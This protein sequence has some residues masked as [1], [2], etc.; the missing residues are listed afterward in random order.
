MG[1]R[2]LEQLHSYTTR[3]TG[4]SATA[5]QFCFQGLSFEMA[6]KFA[7]YVRN[8]HPIVHNGEAL[9]LFVLDSEH[10]CPDKENFIDEAAAVSRRNDA[11]HHFILLQPYG[12]SCSLSVETTVGVI[13]I[14]N[15]AYDD[16][17]ELCD[18]ELY[19]E[20]VSASVH[21][22]GDASQ[23]ASSLIHA[24]VGELLSSDDDSVNEIWGFLGG[25]LDI[26]ADGMSLPH[27][28][29]YCGYPSSQGLSTAEA[30]RL[31]KTFHKDLQETITDT[32]VMGEM[33][34]SLFSEAERDDTV[35]NES[36][37]T[38]FKE[39]IEAEIPNLDASPRLTFAASYRQD[40]RFLPWWNTIVLKDIT[41]AIRGTEDRTALDISAVDALAGECGSKKQPIVFA[42][43]VKFKVKSN[44]AS[45]DEFQ[46]RKGRSANVPIAEEQ[47][48]AGGSIKYTYAL[49]EEE[50][51]RSRKDAGK[52][53]L[54]LGSKHTK[55]TYPCDIQVLSCLKSGMYLTLKDAE[56]IHKIKPFSVKNRRASKTYRTELTV[57]AAGDITCHL[58]VAD[59]ARLIVAPV[60][61]DDQNSERQYFNFRSENSSVGEL[62]S[63]RI[64]AY[65]ELSFQF[66]GVSNGEEY[67]YEVAFFVK[68]TNS[69]TD[70]SPTWYDEHLRRNLL[71]VTRPLSQSDFQEVELASG[72]DIYQLEQ[73]FLLV[74][75]S[76]LGGYPVI[77]GDDYRAIQRQGDRPDFSMPVS[78]T[79][80]PFATNM[81]TRPDFPAWKASLDSFGSGY[82][83]AR[84]DLF[85]R[86]AVEYPEKRIEE[87]DL[88]SLP[89]EYEAL[90][91]RY[92]KAYGEWLAAD[93]A[94]ASIADQIW[95]YPTRD[96]NTL[97][98]L[99][100]EVIYP[101]YHPLR[102]AWL[103][104]A[105]KMMAASESVQPDPAALIFDSNTIPDM[106]HLPIADI[107][108]RTGSIRTIPF[109]SV[110]SSSY[111]WGVLRD[112]SG[113]GSS[114]RAY[115]H[116]WNEM[117]GLSFEKSAQTITKEQVESALNDAR[118]M[119]L[120][121]PSLSVSFSGTS[122]DSICRDGI[123]SWNRQFI[124]EANND[125]QRLGPRRLKIYDVG[126][127]HMP[128][129]EAIAAIGDQSNGMIQWFAPEGSAGAVDLSIATLAAR[130]RS[131]RESTLG[132][133]VTVAGG[134]GCYRTRQ[135]RAG[136][137]LIE[138]RKTRSVVGWRDGADALSVAISSILQ[139]IVT[140]AGLQIPEEK[141]HIGFP[142]DVRSLLSNEKS[143]Y[144]AVSSADV[145]H[146]CFV[147]ESGS[148]DA[149]LWDY[150]LP[151]N[152]IGSRNADGFYL[153]ARETPVMCK[154]VSQAIAS[155]SG[156]NR[157][158]PEAVI[159]NTLHITAQRGIPTVKDLTLGGTKALGEV[160]ILIAV[161][162]LQGDITTTLS[163]GIFPPLVEDDNRAWLNFVV[164]FDPFRRQF[165]SLL[166]SGER[167]VRPDLACIS[168][169]CD[170]ADSKLKPVSA[171]FSFIEVK[172]RTHRF[173]DTDRQQALRQY[174]TCH[175]L[176]SS[177][178][179]G[180]K[181]SLH[182][183][184]VYDFLVSLL[185]FGFRVFSTFT[186]ADRLY[187]DQFY[188]DAVAAMFGDKSFVQIEH[189]PRLLVVD[190]GESAVL[191]KRG[192]VHCVLSLNGPSVC[193]NIAASE[194]IVLP[195]G[196]EPYW[197]LLANTPTL[198]LEAPSSDQTIESDPPVLHVDNNGSAPESFDELPS[199]V[200]EEV[201]N[202]SYPENVVATSRTEMTARTA[203]SPSTEPSIDELLQQ[204]MTTVKQDL[205]DALG[206]AGIRATLVEEPKFSPNSLIF[207]FD[208]TPRSMSVTAI[209]TRITDIKVHYG[210]DIRRIVPLRRKVSIHVAREQRQKVAWE[211]AWPLVVDECKRDRKLYVGV[212][213]E[214]GRSLFLESE[215][216]HAP[217][218]LIAGAT[219]SGKSVLMRNLLFGIAAIYEPH[220]A[221]IILID[222]KMGQD[223][224]AFAG[225][226]HLYGGDGGHGW[227]STQEEA[228]NLLQA[229]F[230]EMNTRTR[231]LSKYQC[232]NLPQYQ[233]VVGK[234]SPDWMPALW[235]FHDEFALWMLDRDYK[236]LV[237]STI[238][239]LAVMARSVGIHLVFATQRPS[240]DVVTPQVRANLGN[241][242]VLKV[243]DSNNSTI[244]LGR[245]GA[246]N[247][248]GLGH[249][250]LKREGEDGDEPVEGQV[251]FHD[252]RDIKAQ[253]L[254]IINAN[255][256]VA[257]AEPLVSRRGEN[258]P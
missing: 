116:L 246:E 223:Y 233:A 15:N 164:P 115:E 160:G 149:Y 150:R 86:L 56:N 194:A 148:G 39:F 258:I 207:V 30:G 18:S 197:G 47:L 127:S 161:S 236:Q 58:F 6:E 77:L 29:A 184:A 62:Y 85:S 235:V 71:K 21:S 187:L 1:T 237:D 173:S 11:T 242:L 26:T 143:S 177:V 229:L 87:I 166:Q 114:V 202:G 102:L 217:H 133:S 191:D 42:D 251:A 196:L 112:Y 52:I 231:M 93:Y 163:S 131:V 3:K 227:I 89:P 245:P 46:V 157:D 189:E 108:G 81:D 95:V 174:S 221:R 35:F 183:L 167:K 199:N 224:Y 79:R 25:L 67:T 88:A 8:G 4:Q 200:S 250:L 110:R 238:A 208:G 68:Q 140:H 234:D 232:E 32:V 106:I 63:F 17:D 111:Y 165:E 158:I 138:S 215:G 7:E 206:E 48:S 240:A 159:K 204:E 103:Y 144:Y 69:S 175:E 190:A 188:T 244:A 117:F 22:G 254:D 92:A 220:E 60:Q 109:F 195:S 83:D 253:V 16:M 222:P 201:L 51:S 152:N 216:R 31:Q 134:L 129:N 100:L 182:T 33:M 162:V 2:L 90:I 239:Q 211:S 59:T 124:D 55:K 20:I 75:A 241:R 118:E 41:K 198:P 171:K 122:C 9:W 101:P 76:G 156:S 53:K 243:A 99:P 176:L 37:V 126:G 84:F 44:L 97:D 141:S 40:R 210:V 19:K 45:D 74:A 147:A 12:T 113:R 192:G 130:E 226:P 209:Q 193:G 10:R 154:A 185:T 225:L 14:E 125:I 252:K 123:I 186:H 257:L 146:A 50:K 104:R 153:L 65:N 119:C 120:A 54:F 105:Q 128:S 82:R 137:Y 219:N 96:N 203:S 145:D 247:L 169:L 228:E 66:K 181:M 170:K 36:D 73:E 136:S 28:E 64:S 213:E 256:E 205:L 214:D 218:T 178:V 98:E 57:I 107:G 24:S 34:D 249:I 61:Y 179:S 91:C 38:A 72:K 230:V 13:G 78:Y 248:L 142:T 23:Y 43:K 49:T 70:M 135:L 255:S 151:Q 80:T 94:N 172:A 27:V 139:G 121:K 168:I 155:I 5:Q 132:D 212:A 180:D